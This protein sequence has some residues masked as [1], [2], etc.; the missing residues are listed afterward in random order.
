MSARRGVAI[1]A[2][3]S[4]A[5]ALIAWSVT[6]QA[7][8]KPSGD[9]VANPYSPAYGH[10]YRHGVQPTTDQQGAMS[11]WASAHGTTTA[12]PTGP[13][14]LAYG[15]GV[16]GI[17]VTS[18]T[19]RVYV[20][21]WGSQWGTQGKDGNG[22]LTFTGDPQ[23]GAP[24]L[25]NMYR[26]LGTNAEQ[27]SGT[28][29]Q[30]CDGSLVS[31][32]ATSCPS[33]ALHVGYPSGGALVD[34]WY[35]NSALAPTA[36]TATQLGVEAVKAASHF[37]NTTPASNRYSQYVIASPTGLNPDH[38][39]TGG[40]CAWHDW[41]GDV[42]AAS[43]VGDVAF[44]NLPYLMD[45]G[46]HCGAGI[47]TSPGTLDG[48]SIV[49]GHEYA[50]TITDQ[51]P[52]GGWTN[53]TGGTA[54][55]QENG[56]ECAWITSGQGAIGLVA[57]STGNF[58]MQSTWSNDTNECDL[59]HPVVS[60]SGNVVT[61]TPPGAQTGTVGTPAN[62]QITAGDTSPTATLT[63]TATGLPTGL[64][65]DSATGL[66]SGTPSAAGSFTPKVTV[67]DDT[68]AF[69]SASFGWTIASGG[70]TGCPSPN[71]R[72]GNPGFESGATVWSQST[73]LIGQWA[74][75]GEPPNTG[76]WDA[77]LGGRG[78]TTT[79]TLAQKVTIP[80]GCTA[81]LSFY[82]HIDTAETTTTA[83]HDR[84]VV[85]IGTTVLATYSNLTAAAGY[86]LHTIDVS[87]YAGQTLK[88]TFKGTENSSLQTS[89]VLDDT[90]LTVS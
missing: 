62:L 56:D 89:F 68:G 7:G 5:A 28:M 22:N 14:T 27:W 24:Y 35:D 69:G 81:T 71:Q 86:V 29:T 47:A 15:G 60:G 84:L 39:K 76:N 41:N 17:G 73:A 52:A 51:N 57:L 45:R 48:Y 31:P 25:Q 74:G 8:T 58:P 72:F 4:T 63:Y 6:A 87:A 85:K 79:E 75:S 36:A 59:A 32:G 26:G 38:Y 33:G 50:E 49:S 44:T 40:F 54:N 11:A 53:Q 21:F 3:V 19:P 80:A 90:A 1:V 65:I 42:G 61:V 64:S 12:A 67:T 82:L 20:V 23:H 37:G 66:I 9:W 43:S 10:S 13:D 16:D 18:G 46:Y 30:Y 55:G 2:A 83:L 88:V 70:A 78:T 34:V 77:W